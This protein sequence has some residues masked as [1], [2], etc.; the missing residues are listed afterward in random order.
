MLGCR[1]SSQASLGPKTVELIQDLPIPT[2]EEDHLKDRKKALNDPSFVE[3]TL[4]LKRMTSMLRPHWESVEETG[5]T[6]NMTMTS[7][8]DPTGLKK[9]QTDPKRDQ[10]IEIRSLTNLLLKKGIAIR[11]ENHLSRMRCLLRIKD[12][13]P[14]SNT[15]LTESQRTLI[16]NLTWSRRSMTSNSMNRKSKFWKIWS[17]QSKTCRCKD[18]PKDRFKLIM[19][20]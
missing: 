5:P 2:T 12:T 4:D 10:A 13:L 18:L 16:T 1:M 8:W 19:S 15:I 20:R 17:G 6:V 7:T 3:L 9:D 11:K 14:R